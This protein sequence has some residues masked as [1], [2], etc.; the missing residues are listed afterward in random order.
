MEN[1]REKR[2]KLEVGKFNRDSWAI[3]AYVSI[4]QGTWSKGGAVG[5]GEH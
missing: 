5:L 2:M 3:W 1:A 4:N